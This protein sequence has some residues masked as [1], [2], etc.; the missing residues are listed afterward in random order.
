MKKIKCL[1]S[2]TKT[3]FFNFLE[4][5]LLDQNMTQTQTKKFEKKERV[6]WGKRRRLC[7]GKGE[8]CKREK[9]KVARGK[10]RRLCGGK[11]EGC[12]REKEK[13]V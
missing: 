9:E 8:G 2:F 13:V 12:K 7:G 3:C 11:G 10:R 5:A 6:V 4:K 1:G